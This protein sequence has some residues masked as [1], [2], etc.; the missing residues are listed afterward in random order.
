MSIVSLQFLLYVCILVFL[1]YILPKRFQWFYLLLASILY[2]WYVCG[3]IITLLML[4]D[5]V[6]VYGIT[7]LI[8]FSK[9]P[10][11]KKFYCIIGV[12]LSLAILLVLKD[13]KFFTG[14]SLE[15][16][17]PLGISFYS[18]VLIGYI[19]D[20]YWEKIKPQNN[21]LKFALFPTYFPQ[22][23]SGPFVRYEEMSN[24]LYISKK[25]N[26][27][28]LRMGV[29]RIAWGFFLKLVISE[30]LAVMVNT[31][32]DNIAFYS[33]FYIFIAVT[34]FV[35]QLYTDFSGYM[36]IVLGI[37]EILGINLPENFKTPFFSRSLAEFWRRWHITLGL[38]MKDYVM[39]PILKSVAFEKI[40]DFSISKF[41]KKI[42]KQIPTYIALV[43]I[44][45][46]VGFWH[47]GAWNFIFGVGL[48]QG[49]FIII[50]QITKKKTDKLILKLK[51]KTD[52][53]S[54][55][56]FQSIRTFFLFALGVCFF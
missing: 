46:L 31:I 27:E 37:S 22:I 44:W 7:Q 49:F 4:G 18:L 42:G 10:K 11:L 5:L 26:Y 28:N 34:C 32:Y 16:A 3:S 54:W 1:Y 39:Y 41:G 36:H 40:R 55:H 8:S 14:F 15:I 45:F 43:I 33:G 51:I 48:L 30:R 6:I 47:G 17:A 24:Q 56:L 12:I 52:C 35:F 29:Q 19:L 38:W 53:F 50:G 23:S 25:F 2:Y 21:I 13:F 9:K 20:V